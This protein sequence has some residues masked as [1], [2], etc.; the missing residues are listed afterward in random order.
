[1]GLDV[2]LKAP[3]AGCHEELT[4]V[5]S[6]CYCL[7]C[8]HDHV[9]VDDDPGGSCQ[10][11]TRCERWI[12][13]HKWDEDCWAVKSVYEAGLSSCL[14]DMA[15]AAWLYNAIWK[16]DEIGI[17]KAR[18]MVEPLKAGLNELISR[19]KKYRLFNAANEWGTYEHFVRGVPG[20]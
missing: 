10:F 5:T 1:M 16:P 14:I 12:R 11:C 8:C 13:P 19:P 4:V 3:V 15:K 17:V 6:T 2:Y 18:Q 20:C 7:P 9:P